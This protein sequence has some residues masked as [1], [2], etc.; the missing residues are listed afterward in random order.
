MLFSQYVKFFA[1]GDKSKHVNI[2]EQLNY[3]F[4]N[5]GKMINLKL[6]KY[7]LY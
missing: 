5:S 4:C 2:F 1:S 7:V 3:S 6:C